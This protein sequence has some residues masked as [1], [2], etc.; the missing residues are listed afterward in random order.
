MSTHLGVVGKINVGLILAIAV[1]TVIQVNTSKDDRTRKERSRLYASAVFASALLLWPIVIERAVGW[2]TISNH[3]SLALGFAWTGM[4]LF[5]EM[6]GNMDESGSDGVSRQKAAETKQWASIIIGAAWAVGTL[7]SVIRSGGSQSV[8][9]SKILLSS[10]VLCIAFIVPLS[11]E[12]SDSRTASSVALRSAQRSA[13]HYS[14]GLFI[15]G[16]TVSCQSM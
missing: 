16:I 15:V 9:G 5:W 13:L 11:S 6:T 10:L 7:L 4:L 8:L 14:V 12:G 1:A 3:V 2:N